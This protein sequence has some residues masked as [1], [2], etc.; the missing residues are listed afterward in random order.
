MSGFEFD[1]SLFPLV[2]VRTPA[3]FEDADFAALFHRFEKN[4][5]RGERY[6]L[7]LDTTPVTT[8]PTAKQRAII[9]TWEKA[10]FDETR[11]WNVGTALV[12]T[13]ALVRGVLTA[14]A[15]IVPDETPRVHVG[16]EREG[17]EWCTK[18][19]TECGIELRPSLGRMRIPR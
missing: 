15:W 18:R 13:S 10:H 5:Q 16:T 8:V 19:L 6:A 4:F 3:Q 1:D 9:S 11:R 17:V 12:V 7:L 2:V 14:L